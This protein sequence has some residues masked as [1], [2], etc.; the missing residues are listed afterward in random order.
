MSRL[1]VDGPI[2]PADRDKLPSGWQDH[3]PSS[4]TH[5]TKQF[6]RGLRL[7]LAGRSCA[8][9]QVQCGVNAESLRKVLS[10]MDLTRSAKEAQAVRHL[11]E[12]RHAARLF[13]RR[14]RYGPMNVARL[15]GVDKKTVICWR[16]DW[17][18]DVPLLDWGTHQ[19]A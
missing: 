2:P 11:E 1:P 17:A 5:T 16:E 15:V 13:E 3:L 8:Q 10:R 12:R 4:R 18:N 9:C 6:E 14:R 19:G 7:Y